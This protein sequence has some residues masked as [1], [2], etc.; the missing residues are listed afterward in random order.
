MTVFLIQVVVAFVAFAIR[1]AKDSVPMHFVIFPLANVL[2]AVA[3]FVDTYRNITTKVSSKYE[4]Q[5][6]ALTLALN[7][8]VVEV[9][10]VRVAVRPRESAN[11]L[12]HALAVV[13]L[14][15]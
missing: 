6:V 12:L 1:P 3:P 9:A 13:A 15:L 2:T 11:A 8:V 7:V 10:L 14:E 4:Q 5:P